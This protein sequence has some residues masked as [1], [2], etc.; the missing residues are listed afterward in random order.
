M[1]PV[2]STDYLGHFL[3]ATI[4]LYRNDNHDDELSSVGIAYVA[5]ATV[6]KHTV[7]VI[8]ERDAPTILVPA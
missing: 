4:I 6:G 5:V 1:F 2:P 7:V 3:C 8:G